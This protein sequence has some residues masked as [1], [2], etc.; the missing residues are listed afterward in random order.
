MA[1]PGEPEAARVSEP[2]TKPVATGGLTGGKRR[3]EADE[4]AAAS[5]STRSESMLADSVGIYDREDRPRSVP[6]NQEVG[7][8]EVAA[9]DSS[10]MQRRDEPSRRVDE[11][12]ALG[13]I[14]AM[15]SDV[16]A[17][18]GQPLGEDPAPSSAAA[19][20]FHIGP[21][22]GHREVANGEGFRAQPGTPTA[23]R[24]EP[25]EELADRAAISVVA[26]QDQGRLRKREDGGRAS[27]LER[28]ET[29]IVQ[30]FFDP[31]DPRPD[32]GR[33]LDPGPAGHEAGL[34]RSE[35]A[36]A[37]KAAARP[38]L[39]DAQAS[40]SKRGRETGR[41][42]SCRLA[43]AEVRERDSPA[44]GARP[45]GRQRRQECGQVGSSRGPLQ[46]GGVEPP[47][48]T[49]SDPEV[50]EVKI[51]VLP[52]SLMQSAHGLADEGGEETTAA[53]IASL[54]GGVVPIESFEDEP[55]VRRCDGPGNG[56][57]HWEPSLVRR[58]EPPGLSPSPGSE[59]ASTG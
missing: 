14:R 7:G 34:D 59:E 48:S 5:P 57:R 31:L 38:S 39:P 16:E 21:G 20:R 56:N 15:P 58:P 22:P 32:C 42:A 1:P 35:G 30:A 46:G 3:I 26:L 9:A 19:R 36:I 8:L 54:E 45:G 51:A 12:E 44:V 33:P 53:R 27:A 25:T 43:V 55:I 2:P 40:A 10:P 23:R 17:V 41:M 28:L 11:G 47:D 29:R 13:A 49:V 52:A 24:G 37:S 50:L 4:V 18:C 6:S